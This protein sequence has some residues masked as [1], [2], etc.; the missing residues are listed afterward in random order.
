MST[1]SVHDHRRDM[2]GYRYVYPVASR[3]A[4]GVSVG[5]NLNPNNACN[6]ACVY[7]QVPGLIRG[8]AP[9]I[10]LEKLESE[11][12]E[13]LADIVD[14]DWLARNVPKGA[15]VLQDIAFSGNGEPTSAREFPAAV[16][17]VER[18]LDEFDLLGKL[19]VRL[20]TNGS[21][22]HRQSVLDAIA[23][24]ATINGEVWFK[25][26][27]ATSE[28]IALVNSVRGN[29]GGIKR[30]LRACAARCPTWVQ[31]CWFNLDGV[32]LS[33]E[34][35]NAYLALI[36]EVRTS[37]A[38]VHLYGLARQPMQPGAERLCAMPEKMLLDYGQQIRKLGVQVN[39][40]P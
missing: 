37:I 34:E 5:I 32:P 3:R 29:P 21:L 30:R 31:T 26:D 7:C 39:V 36:G 18:I 8:D 12:H 16:E 1:L 24:L 19:K 22:M 13:F 20:I 10:D 33:N 9:P 14:G 23:K 17:M 35:F 25:I 4:G 28:G 27:R 15:W 11:L 40:S 2:A 38:G 6:W